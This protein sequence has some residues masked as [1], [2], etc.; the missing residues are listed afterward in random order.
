MH[1]ITRA[2][3]TAADI[4]ALRKRVRD[5]ELAVVAAQNELAKLQIDVLNTEAHN[6]RLSETLALLE[7]ELGEKGGAVEKYELEIKR[8]N[9]EIEKKT[10]EIDLLNRK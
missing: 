2:D 5:E 6:T 8:R 1:T 7:E 3:K 4:R 10:R 9:D